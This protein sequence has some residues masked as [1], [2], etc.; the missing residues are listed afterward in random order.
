MYCYY[1]GVMAVSMVRIADASPVPPARSG[2]FSALFGNSY[3]VGMGR[4]VVA[5]QSTVNGG[6]S[7]LLTDIWV[8]SLNTSQW[9]EVDPV[10]CRLL[11][12][13]AQTNSC[14]AAR[15]HPGFTHFLHPILNN[16]CI[17]VHGGWLNSLATTND[18]WYFDTVRS[19][20]NLVNF[21][22]STL[23]MNRS[24]HAVVYFNSLFY[25][26]GGQNSNASPSEL[27]ALYTFD[28]VSAIWNTI[29]LNG[30]PQFGCIYNM[31][32]LFGSF[33]LLYCSS[34]A[35]LYYVDL[36]NNY[37]APFSNYS[38]ISRDNA[39][40]V[41]LNGFIYIMGDSSSEFSIITARIS[42]NTTNSFSNDFFP[43][44]SLTA[45]TRSGHV[46]AIIQIPSNSGEFLDYG[47]VYGGS[48]AYASTSV[49]LASGSFCGIGKVGDWR[50]MIFSTTVVPVYLSVYTSYNNKVYIFGG[51]ISADSVSWSI[52][53]S[54]YII[55]VDPSSLNDPNNLHAYT[56]RFVN[57]TLSLSS[58]LPFLYASAGTF[59]SSGLRNYTLVYGGLNSTNQATNSFYAVDLDSFVVTILT[60]SPQ[61][62]YHGL[63]TIGTRL[64]VI[65]TNAKSVAVY[66][67]D[68]AFTDGV[69]QN[70]G[71]WTQQSVSGSAISVLSNRIGISYTSVKSNYVLLFG[72]VST[73]Y[74]IYYS[75][76]WILDVQDWTFYQLSVANNIPARAFAPIIYY[77]TRS[78]IIISGGV[79]N[80]AG[81]SYND[82]FLIV[83]PFSEVLIDP[84]EGNNYNCLK[85]PV[86]TFCLTLNHAYSV[87]GGFNG[88]FQNF[89]FTSSKPLN[90]SYN[91]LSIT[92][93]IKI[94]PLF[95]AAK[96][97]YWNCQQ[98]FC[99]SINVPTTYIYNTITFQ[100]INLFNGNNAYGG[101]V[102]FLAG[103]FL[104][105][106][107]MFHD[108]I[109]S[110]GGAVYAVINTTL[111]FQ[112]CNFWN[113]TALSYGGAIFS[114]FNMVIINDSNFTQNAVYQPGAVSFYGGGALGLFSVSLIMKSGNFCSNTA[115]GSALYP[116]YGGAV[117]A[118]STVMKLDSVIFDHNVADSGGAIAIRGFTDSVSTSSTF[119]KSVFTSSGCS[120]VYNYARLYGGAI[121]SANSVSH[122][123][124]GD[125]FDAN[126]AYSHG[127]SV[128]LSS[129]LGTTFNSTSLL[130]SVSSTQYGGAIYAT[131]S[132]LTLINVLL[133]NNSALNGAGG[134]F[135][136]ER[137]S[138]S[139]TVYVPIVQ[140]LYVSGN[141][142]QYGSNYA[143]NGQSAT[144]LTN[145]A[146]YGIQPCGSFPVSPIT[147]AVV[148]YY[149]QIT[150]T[151]NDG[152]F[153]AAPDSYWNGVI[154]A[155]I[156]N[157]TASFT[158]LVSVVGN[159]VS[160]AFYATSSTI[161]DSG[162]LLSNTFS[163]Q[164]SV[165][166]PGTIDG[167]SSGCVSCS[168]GHYSSTYM[169]KNCSI[170]R[171]G[172]FSDAG[173]STC[174][175]CAA[176]FFSSISGASSCVQCLD[177]TAQPTQGQT[178]CFS[179][180]FQSYS[181]ADH[182]SCYCPALFYSNQLSNAA[183]PVNFTCLLC[184]EW[185]SC[186]QPG[187]TYD[188]VFPQPGYYPILNFNTSDPTAL[189]FQGCL[190]GSACVGDNSYYCLPG[191]TGA[192]CAACA[193]GYEISSQFQCGPCLDPAI[194]KA[195]LILVAFGSILF[196]MVYAHI[197]S[198]PKKNS[199]SSSVSQ[200][201]VVCVQFNS[202]VTA[203]SF[204]WPY[205]LSSFL[206]VQKGAA[207]AAGSVFS[208]KCFSKVLYPNL[209]FFYIIT[210]LYA[211]LPLITTL[212][213]FIVYYLWYRYDCHFNPSKASWKLF[214]SRSVGASYVIFFFNH[215]DIASQVF[216]TF[217][218][219]KV[220]NGNNDFFLVAD[221]SQR[222]WT[223][224]HWNWILYLT[225]PMLVVYVIMVPL[226]CFLAMWKKSGNLG[227]EKA[228]AYQ[229]MFLKYQG[230][231]W[232]WNFFFII[233]QV[234]LVA[235]VAFIQ[236]VAE[237][238]LFA[239]FLCVSM[240]LMHSTTLPFYD[241]IV[242]NFEFFGLCASFITYFFSSL[243][244]VINDPA[245]TQLLSVLVLL[246][247]VIF[248]LTGIVLFIFFKYAPQ[249]VIKHGAAKDQ[250]T[251]SKIQIDSGKPSHPP[252]MVADESPIEIDAHKSKAAIANAAVNAEEMELQPIHALAMV[253][254]PLDLSVGEAVSPIVSP[255][256]SDVPRKSRR[257]RAPQGPKFVPTDAA[258]VPD[259]ELVQS[260]MKLRAASR[261][262]DEEEPMDVKNMDDLS[263]GVNPEYFI[264]QG[265]TN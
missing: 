191:Y 118:V 200:V 2:H 132:P 47:I 37:T 180:P 95:G 169:A 120:Y 129:A 215:P 207:Y 40:T 247:N 13:D 237:Q 259:V 176:G 60:G 26:F 135:Y 168:T 175:K 234:V 255:S 158:S 233:R 117:Y 38:I 254:I 220:G 195:R 138:S 102:N 141:S 92:T 154:I 45:S 39:S 166:A 231:Y 106:N 11:S 27:N 62:I 179:C 257:R 35:N 67:Y 140:G 8:F 193:D 22:G 101:I 91:Q 20:W 225:I 71:V 96:P 155:P 236:V 182:K 79:F 185:A 121:F 80:P 87:F 130:N 181:S 197:N 203:F 261:Q 83:G 44:A 52:S 242:N 53:N 165:C 246:V 243:I 186:S 146:T 113:L 172:S 122:L 86:L 59:I 213:V 34:Y 82:T 199:V 260:K 204:V 224:E 137:S 23:P 149:Q 219:M 107:C 31:P 127:G 241:D 150:T 85:A 211:I 124:S 64:I 178:A 139:Q 88:I 209:S 136:W 248:I 16:T 235:I 206:A 18:V 105:T 103:T 126:W 81:D 159:N 99:V 49:P 183:N 93:P 184:P 77:Y 201:A 51:K 9:K 245:I 205:P 170:C 46:L 43:Y 116:A 148:D 240:M 4:G 63:V 189:G 28:I 217:K 174:T 190:Y 128:Y 142:A 194:N 123:F 162:F 111:I 222:C 173:S 153:N 131:L 19:N 145:Q 212:G 265:Q 262:T 157:G 160:Y 250:A 12:V 227:S 258:L 218:C 74:P 202:V 252:E 163:L 55:D 156:T 133:V 15:M 56:F 161:Y 152:S 114:E 223:T 112:S 256:E 24:G 68:P 226:I 210:V 32:Q 98:S 143:S 70:G 251:N 5:T 14:P 3:I 66:S 30:S 188:T 164:S 263:R 196:F 171:R 25:L 249:A 229:F 221:M 230:K 147:V 110:F 244:F 42:A 100:Y 198:D 33:M 89:L 214:F 58:S 232:Y 72:G 187:L 144:V 239:I 264:K 75:D 36:V 65:N 108:S 97:I 21:S 125:S 76:L 54:L 17:F 29:S 1:P 6:T 151:L 73:I 94:S 167:G 48:S 69:L 208:V 228:A 50:S 238:S 104:A 115:T 177:G 41:L 90:L 10:G 134:G 192:L 119:S 216:N 7:A 109:A 78:S 84:Y 61:L 253:D 57:N